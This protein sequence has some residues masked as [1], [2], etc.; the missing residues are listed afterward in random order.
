M[1][2]QR[3]NTVGTST[4]DFSPKK[5][6]PRVNDKWFQ[7]DCSTWEIMESQEGRMPCHWNKE[8]KGWGSSVG[9]VE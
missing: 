1:I 5:G 2:R 6:L 7:V 3:Q 8:S 9:T 4:V